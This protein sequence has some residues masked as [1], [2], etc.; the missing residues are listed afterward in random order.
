MRGRTPTILG[1][2]SVALFLVAGVVAVPLGPAGS[3]F[4]LLICAILAV[5][6]AVQAAIAE[7]RD[8]GWALI[9][10]L[11]PIVALVSD[12]SPSG[13]V[14]PLGVLLFLACELNALRWRVGP[15]A[16]GR[17]PTRQQIRGVVRL[18]V[19][20]T[21]GAGITLWAAAITP[22]A[23]TMAVALAALALA[24][25]GAAVFGTG[26]RGGISSSG[27]PG[28]TGETPDERP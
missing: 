24:G 20:G 27:A 22:P 10:G 11:V 17:R 25:A 16:L 13:L 18:S 19:F 7:P 23:T 1:S 15:P 5:L 14:V 12:G 26:W 2:L 28:V 3:R 9:L 4:V 8:L 21:V 6:M